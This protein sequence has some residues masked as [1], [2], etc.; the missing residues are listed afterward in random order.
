MAW[1]K[2]SIRPL[3]G[4]GEW[5]DTHPRAALLLVLALAAGLRMINLDAKTLWYD[6]A[7]AVLYAEKDLG[8]ILYGTYASVQGA[9]ADVHPVSYYA[10]LHFWLALGQAPWVVR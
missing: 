1:A 10:L 7:F 9:A 5:V 2:G 6:E 4:V 3:A 8:A